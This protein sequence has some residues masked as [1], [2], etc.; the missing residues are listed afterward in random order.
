MKYRRILLGFIMF[1]ISFYCTGCGYL[2]F[3]EPASTKKQVEARL[4]ERYGEKFCVAS[5]E[6]LQSTERHYN[7]TAY[8]IYPVKNP[9]MVFY[10]FESVYHDGYFPSQWSRNLAG[11]SL[12]VYEGAFIKEEVLDCLEQNGW[13]YEIEYRNSFVDG[14]DKDL[15]EKYDSSVDLYIDTEDL[16]ADREKLAENMEAVMQKLLCSVYGERT[17]ISRGLSPARVFLRYKE[18]EEMY[19]ERILVLDWRDLP[20]IRKDAIVEYFK[21]HKYPAGIF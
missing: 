13:E 15:L 11:S 17:T 8:E 12:S 5:T 16:E 10:D 19:V 7:I 1:A 6:K 4:E 2:N 18:G 14:K 20:E 9:E 3:L 21:S